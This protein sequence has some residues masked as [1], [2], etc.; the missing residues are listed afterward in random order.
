MKQMK[1]III[2]VA[3]AALL[4]AGCAKSPSSK[5]TDAPKRYLEAW[6]QVQKEKHP[7]YLWTQTSLGA[8]LLEDEAGTGTPV[9]EF[10]DSFYV[11][12]NYTYTD[13]TGKIENTT[14]ARISQQLGTYRETNYYG[15]VVW[16]AKG[17]YAGLEDVIKGMKPGGR[18]KA[19]IP[20]WLMTYDRYDTVDGYLSASQDKNG[21]N[22][23]YELE[24]VECFDYVNEWEVDSIG[25]YL[26]HNFASKYGK[27]ATK[28][29]ADSSGAHGFYY[30]S[31]G[32]PSDAVELKDTTVYINY[33]GRLLNGQVF[34]TNIRDTAIFHGIFSEGG[35]YKPVSVNYGSSWS[36][37]KMGEDSNS[38][39]KGFARTLW[40]MKSFE[41]GTGVF[42][43]PLG[44]GYRGSGAS[45][46]AY[47]PLRFD[48]QIVAKP[49]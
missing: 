48:I 33:I 22:G 36:E 29:K 11:R 31:D 30:I 17:I 24:L 19:V 23:I 47:S 44:Y 39:I 45:I 34:D 41:V 46:P 27:D 37:V 2:F 15:P 16:Y 26:A 13:L 3:A 42:Y 20:S 35:S 5:S 21:S 38:V 12:V 7:E 1:R 4:F 14:S 32:A 25:R 9:G 40:S 28:A 18:R 10:Q 8:W 6:V 49:E 43:S